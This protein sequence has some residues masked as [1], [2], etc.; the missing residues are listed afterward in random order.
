[1]CN[2]HPP[3]KYG[4]LG[5]TKPCRPMARSFW[6]VPHMAR[7]ASFTRTGEASA[8]NA[9]A[10]KIRSYLL[11]HFIA[12]AVQERGHRIA[13][14]RLTGAVGAVIPALRNALLGQPRDLLVELAVGGYVLE[15]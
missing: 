11:Q 7:G 3:Q 6:A 8:P 4:V 5:L 12:V 9:V 2:T 1:M 15:G 14:N 10:A 13:V